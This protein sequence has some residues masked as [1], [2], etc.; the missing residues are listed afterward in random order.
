VTDCGVWVALSAVAEG[1]LDS[2]NKRRADARSACVLG[3]SLG[4][5]RKPLC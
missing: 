1:G 5:R 3:H 4:H 2:L